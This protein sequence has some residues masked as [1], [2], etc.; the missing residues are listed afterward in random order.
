MVVTFV[1]HKDLTNVKKLIVTKV[2]DVAGYGYK[3]VQE[4]AV[5]KGSKATFNIDFLT[6]NKIRNLK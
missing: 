6:I 3:L 4:S 1:E 5:C 2:L